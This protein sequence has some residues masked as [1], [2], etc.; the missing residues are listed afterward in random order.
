MCA[1]E[2]ERMREEKPGGLEA[3]HGLRGPRLT[4]ADAAAALRTLTAHDDVTKERHSCVKAFSPR[5]RVTW[6]P[7]VTFSTDRELGLNERV[8]FIPEKPHD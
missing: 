5:L 3:D 1:S 4:Y 8:A 7:A 2:L 6:P